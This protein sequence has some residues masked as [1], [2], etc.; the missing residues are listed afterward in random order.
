MTDDLYF[1]PY[2]V[3]HYVFTT[4]DFGLLEEKVPFINFARTEG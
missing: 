3:Q 1:L 2:V 4:G